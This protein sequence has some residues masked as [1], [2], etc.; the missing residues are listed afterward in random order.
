[1]GVKE[2]YKSPQDPQGKAT[3]WLT[4]FK[5]MH[6]GG[7]STMVS[8]EYDDDEYIY[9]VQF[10]CLDGQNIGE[11]KLMGWKSLVIVY[12]ISKINILSCFSEI[13]VTFS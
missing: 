11:N 7:Q 3:N 6:F 12:D 1:M 4:V 13:N 8:V 2:L 9:D 10:Y 5:N